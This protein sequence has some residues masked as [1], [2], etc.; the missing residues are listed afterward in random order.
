M[1]YPESIKDSHGVFYAHFLFLFIFLFTFYDKHSNWYILRGMENNNKYI[2]QTKKRN[3]NSEISKFQSWFF[4]LMLVAYMTLTGPFCPL[5]VPQSLLDGQQVTQC[6]FKW[7]WS[8]LHGGCVRIRVHGDVFTYQTDPQC[9]PQYNPRNYLWP[10]VLLLE[11][12]WG[13]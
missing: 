5:V 7:R 1:A 6:V 2:N 3:G 13:H 10:K 11:V 8:D 12:V 4:P 9:K